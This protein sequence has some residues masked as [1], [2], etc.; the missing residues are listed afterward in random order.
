MSTQV[1]QL[2]SRLHSEAEERYNTAMARILDEVEEYELVRVREAKEAVGQ[3]VD[4]MQAVAAGSG[5][6]YS[7]LEKAV[8][9]CS[10]EV[11]LFEFVEAHSRGS[12]LSCPEPAAPPQQPAIEASVSAPSVKHKEQLPEV[13]I[14][15]FPAEAEALSAAL[16]EPT[17]ADLAMV[18]FTS[19]ILSKPGQNWSLSSEDPTTPL[20]S[21]I[22]STLKINSKVA[23]SL[24]SLYGSR[25]ASTLAARLGL[26]LPAAELDLD[27][28]LLSAILKAEV[29]HAWS[30][31]AWQV[32]REQG[33]KKGAESTY[34][35][36]A[37]L[38][39]AL[40]L[41]ITAVE[42][43]IAEI[44]AKAQQLYMG[45]P[46]LV[47]YS[48]PLIETLFGGSGDELL[49]EDWEKLVDFYGD[50]A[51]DSESLTLQYMTIVHYVAVSGSALKLGDQSQRIMQALWQISMYYSQR[52]QGKDSAS[53]GK[54]LISLS[55]SLEI[56][57]LAQSTFQR[58]LP[59]LL[60]A[61]QASSS[62]D[63]NLSYA[64]QLL[65]FLYQIAQQK[66]YDWS[67]FVSKLV[68]GLMDR[69]K[70]YCVDSKLHIVSTLSE[71]LK[72]ALDYAKREISR[73]SLWNEVYPEAYAIY[74]TTL[75]KTLIEVLERLLRPLPRA[76][77]LSSVYEVGE[78]VLK[79]ANVLSKFDLLAHTSLSTVLHPSL[80]YWVQLRS[81]VIEEAVS[82][83]QNHNITADVS[84]K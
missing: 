77:G 33:Y 28:G 37:E 65:P 43:L 42:P 11:D 14:C 56:R 30:Q 12:S 16:P 67:S 55:L 21:H 27:A 59:S 13:S 58:F 63:T 57:L 46:T 4:M 32:K 18:F 71:L 81:S 38:G 10:P 82:R 6:E 41:E 75:S 22:R 64:L 69:L 29:V 35:R 17:K 47:L 62:T 7:K 51:K 24:L 83:A 36:F 80:T 54:T 15:L 1:F 19:L 3:A 49:C 9:L 45:F 70:D 23:S 68:D 78:Q 5:R 50:L 74:S 44:K 31:L 40:G 25:T 8:A 34:S 48:K 26:L 2:N 53:L 39:H 20:I 66:E 76:E 60:E 61:Y 52:I 79:L 73:K 72:I 84:T